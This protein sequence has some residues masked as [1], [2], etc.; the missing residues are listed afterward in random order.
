[1]SETVMP[2]RSEDEYFI[3]QQLEMRKKWARERAEKMAG[4]E[5]NKLRELHF[6]KCPKCGMDL[7]TI[8]LH[9]VRLDQ[10]AACLGTWF[11][12]GEVEQMLHPEREGLFHKVMSLFR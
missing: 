8:E 7:Q 12:K 9:G 11:D 4:E 3:R 2:S 5:K 10:C 1:M 6:M